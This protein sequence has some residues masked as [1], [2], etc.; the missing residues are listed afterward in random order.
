MT[1]PTARLGPCLA[2]LVALASLASACGEGGIPDPRTQADV[3]RAKLALE[4]PE[5]SQ[6]ERV[7]YTVA[8]T[9]LESIPPVTYLTDEFST[10][11]NGGEATRILPC[12]TKPGTGVGLNQVDITAVVWVPGLTAA[13]GNPFTIQSS[14]VF[15]CR[16]NAD[17]LVNV[18]MN[19][20]GAL[21]DGFGDLD[22]VPIGTLCSGKLDFK[23]DT[24]VGVCPTSTCGDTED[25]FL[26]ANTCKSVQAATP[27]FWLCGDPTDWQVNGNAASSFFPVPEHDGEWHFGVTALDGYRMAQPDETLTDELGNLVVWSGAAGVRA[28]MKR[29]QGVNTQGAA[30]TYSFEFAAD[31]AVPPRAQG[32]PSP[33]V[34][35][36]VNQ[37]ELGARVVFQ[38]KLGACD[39]PVED[40]SLYPGLRV[41]DA[42]R[43][44]DEGLKLILA[45]VAPGSFASQVARCQTGWDTTQAAPRP[46]VSCGAPSPLIVTTPTTP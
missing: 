25:I 13:Q 39:V 7:D 22:I 43:D 37:D 16:E 44:G 12:H 20:I 9:Y 23:P 45:S 28:S 1:R 35:L 41:I 8:F 34:L 21:G 27:T 30:Q 36:L 14:A 32:L 3:G 38:T 19:V 42:R 18:T 15:N 17:T 10:V 24:Y 2:S 6:I 4:L 31:L 26:F 46:I 40:V 5:G 29:V 11:T 33:H